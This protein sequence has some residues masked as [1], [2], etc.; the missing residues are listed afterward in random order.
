[1]KQI[2]GIAWSLFCCAAFL[3]AQE[4]SDL[5]WK[6]TERRQV[7]G[8]APVPYKDTFF[9][10]FINVEEIQLRK[11]AFAYKGLLKGELIDMGNI[12]YKVLKR[13]HKVLHLEDGDQV[14]IFTPDVKDLS[15]ADAAVKMAGIKLPETPVQHIEFKDLQGTWS[16]YKRT[17]RDGPLAKLDTKGMIQSL[18]CMEKAG[19]VPSCTLYATEVNGQLLYTIKDIR[20]PYLIVEDTQGIIHEL[21]VWKL[22][23]R[24]LILE[25]HKGILYFMRPYP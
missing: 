6:E 23:P 20:S 15:A 8:Q 21:T 1:M 7:K 12:T 5:R 22:D 9:L 25:D 17:G 18:S 3:S 24:E 13:D 4:H 11:G 19:Q 14:H 2:I 16:A 10:Q